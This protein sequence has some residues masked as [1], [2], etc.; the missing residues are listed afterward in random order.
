MAGVL[1]EADIPGRLGPSVQEVLSWEMRPVPA[2]LRQAF[3]DSLGTEDLDK[4]RYYSREFYRLEVER[5][6]NRVWQMVCR[7]EE[8][9]RVGDHMIYEV[10]DYSLI[11]V[12]SRP[13]EIKAFHNACKH[14]LR[15]PAPPFSHKG[16]ML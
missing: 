11:V 8:I 7:V 5:M 12:R 4:E 9:P 10:G 16:G 6:W 13:N 2:A 15:W 14:H 1:H 3:N